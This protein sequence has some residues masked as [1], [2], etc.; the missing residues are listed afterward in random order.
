MRARLSLLLPLAAAVWP[1]ASVAAQAVDRTDTPRHGALRV[2]FDPQT[3]TWERNFT[4]SGRQGIGA[5]FTADSVAVAAAVPAL[6]RMQQDTRTLT[7]LAGYVAS[8]GHDLLAVRAERRIM[9]IGLEY[10]I[11]DRLSLGVTVPI[12]RV[13]VR[14]AYTLHPPGA[15]VGFGPRTSADSTRYS[16]FFSDFDA[17]LAQLNKNI[18]DSVYGPCSTS[19][20]CQ[21]AQAVFTQDTALRST[22]NSIVYGV[23]GTPGRYLPLASSDAGR[24]ITASIAGVQHVLA[25]SFQVSAFSKDSFLLPETGT[26]D[27]ADIADLYTARTD[28]LALAPYGDTP[29]RLRFFTGD[30]EVQAKMRLL[31][32]NDAAL[33]ASFVVRLPTG[34]QESPSNPFDI[35]TGDHQT[36]LEGRLTGEVTLL[37]RIWLNAAV[38]AAR[39]LPGPRDRRVGPADDPFLLPTTLAH[40]RWDPGDFVAL[41]VAPMFRFSPRF[42]VG[43]TASY[44]AQGQDH[45]GFFSPQDSTAF[46]TQIG[47]PANV[48]VLD[49]G[50][51]IRQTRLGFALTYAGPRLEGGFSVQQTV[52]G[53]GGLVPVATVFRIVMRQ[54][55][56]LF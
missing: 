31:T 16:S 37:N 34:H 35:S 38:R 22:L 20:T 26:A 53:A 3:M 19:Q 30:V 24:Q 47:G 14:A 54:T 21:R 18:A 4:P 7:G 43:L 1:G 10:G 25:D 27:A 12:V 41:D 56:L 6:A 23:A 13:Q 28:S 45:Y 33:A 11:T 48:S 52:S 8:L 15:N 50:T 5:A 44:Y 46:A 42:A 51:A 9:P 32:S 40:L 49:A 55:I 39:Q 29:R 2:S 36:D 17:A